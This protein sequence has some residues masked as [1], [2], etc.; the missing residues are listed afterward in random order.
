VNGYKK[1][2]DVLVHAVTLVKDEEF[3]VEDD[4]GVHVFN[5]YPETFRTV[6]YLVV[7][8]K[9]RCQRKFNF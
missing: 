4:F 9:I 7:P 1:V 5:E 6:V 8:L 3:V 2:D